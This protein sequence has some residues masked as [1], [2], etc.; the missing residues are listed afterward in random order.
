MC[1]IKET[2]EPNETRRVGGFCLQSLSVAAVLETLI[3]IIV[4]NRATT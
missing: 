1:P 2:N 3:L 4:N